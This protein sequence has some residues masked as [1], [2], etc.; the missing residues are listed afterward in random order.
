MSDSLKKS[1]LLFQ[2]LRTPSSKIAN[3]NSMKKV[4]D[5]LE[6][7]EGYVTLM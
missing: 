3:A 6:K 4:R 7:S 2:K 1:N 5:R